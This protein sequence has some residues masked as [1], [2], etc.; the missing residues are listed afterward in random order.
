MENIKIQRDTLHKI[1]GIKK[2]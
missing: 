1:S 2:Y